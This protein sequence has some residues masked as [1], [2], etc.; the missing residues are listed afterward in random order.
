MEF[1]SLFFLF[2]WLPIVLL[3]Y[4]F[5]FRSHFRSL[6]LLAVSL[7][8]YAWGEPL[9]VF[10]LLTLTFI[11]LAAGKGN[12]KNRKDSLD[13]AGYCFRYFFYCFILNTI[14]VY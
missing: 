10:L 2:R 4:R 1:H 7:L 12:T 14:P 3:C 13:V 8:F 9:Y 6:F 11:S 5:F